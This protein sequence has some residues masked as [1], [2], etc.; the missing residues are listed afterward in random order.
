MMI[1]YF[2]YDSYERRR[3]ASSLLKE[4]KRYTLTD[5]WDIKYAFGSDPDAPMLQG[6]ACPFLLSS[7]SAKELETIDGCERIE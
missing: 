1:V 5:T 7:C 2:Y 3:V 4:S 6:A